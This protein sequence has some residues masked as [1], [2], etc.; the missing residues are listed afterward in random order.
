MVN[1]LNLVFTFQDVQS[2]LQQRTTHTHIHTPV[3]ADTGDRLGKVSCP[4][5][6][7]HYAHAGAGIRTPDTVAEQQTDQK[8]I[9]RGNKLEKSNLAAT[10]GCHFRKTLTAKIHVSSVLSI[11]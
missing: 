5:T 4:G 6:Q 1:G 2:G 10:S 8:V 9:P 7:Q 3:Y 11:F